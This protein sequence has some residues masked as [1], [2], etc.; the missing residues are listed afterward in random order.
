MVA[1]MNYAPDLGLVASYFFSQYFPVWGW[2]SWRRAWLE[3]DGDLTGWRERGARN[4][5]AGLCRARNLARYYASMFDQFIDF[6]ID[7]G[8]SSGRTVACAQA[9]WPLFPG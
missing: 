8:I 6:E 4:E 5:L 7:T 1:G 3:C 9:D 2:A